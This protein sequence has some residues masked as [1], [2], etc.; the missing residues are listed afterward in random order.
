MTQKR[1]LTATTAVAV[2]AV[3]AVS[4]SMSFTSLTALAAQAHIAISWGLPVELDAGMLVAS[5]ATITLRKQRSRTVR[6]YP[7]FVV[8]ALASLSIWAN[9][10]HATGG[11]I[12][13]G[14]ASILGA[15][16][17][18]VLLLCG[19]LLLITMTNTVGA[20]SSTPRRSGARATGSSVGSSMGGSKALDGAVDVAAGAPKSDRAAIIARIIEHHRAT[21]GVWPSGPTVAGD[22]LGGSVSRKTGSR[23]VAAARAAVGE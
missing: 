23:L 19:H 4:F 6:G 10:L 12:S 7:V 13:S 21:A 15:T 11:R 1:G 9:A 8:L 17:P 5:L 3:A 16:A 18:V 2:G 14:S 22:W 20:T